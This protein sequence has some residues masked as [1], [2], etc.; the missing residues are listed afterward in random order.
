MPNLVEVT[1]LIFTI[2]ADSTNDPIWPLYSQP[3]SLKPY[4]S[5]VAQVCRRWSQITQWRTNSHFWETMLSLRLVRNGNAVDEMSKDL[6]RMRTVAQFR[7]ALSTIEDGD[8]RL[9]WNNNMQER[10]S[11]EDRTT[12]SQILVHCVAM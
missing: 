12:W 9:F 4:I 7:C 11:A 2:G 3:R 8:I 5:C 6:H 1:S 10:M